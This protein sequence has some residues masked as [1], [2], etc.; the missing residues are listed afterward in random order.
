MS[1]FVDR[2]NARFVDL[3]P[4]ECPK[5]PHDKD[6]MKVRPKLTYGEFLELGEKAR[7]GARQGEFYLFAT[8]I[9]EWSWVDEKGEPVP[10]D[11][12]TFDNLDP[13]TAVKLLSLLDDKSK[14]KAADPKPSGARSP[15][16]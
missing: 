1:R 11:F 5:T 8:K 6:W 14:K 4:C 16:R 15:R 7:E 13:M 10:I 12:E 2:Q 9:I 3:G